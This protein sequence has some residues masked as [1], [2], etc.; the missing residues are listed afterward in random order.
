MVF[1]DKALQKCVKISPWT[2]RGPYPVLHVSVVVRLMIF[3]VYES[4]VG[5]CTVVLGGI[6]VTSGI[7]PVRGQ[8][9]IPR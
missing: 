9:T 4:T 6:S 8:L 3:L 1:A 2:K 5:A 7:Q